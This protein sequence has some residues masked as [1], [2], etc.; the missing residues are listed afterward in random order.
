MPVLVEDA[1]LAPAVEEGAGEVR[2]DEAGSSGNQVF[3]AF[4][5]RA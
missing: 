5:S 4:F 1:D 3:H 2:A